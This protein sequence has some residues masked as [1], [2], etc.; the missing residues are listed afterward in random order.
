MIDCRRCGAARN[1][2]RSSC[3]RTCGTR[4]GATGSMICSPRASRTC[5]RYFT[6][7]E[8]RDV[9]LAQ[10]RALLSHRSRESARQDDARLDSRGARLRHAEAFRAARERR[11]SGKTGHSPIKSARS[12][13]CVTR[14]P[15]VA[16]V[17]REAGVNGFTNGGTE[18]T[19]DELRRSGSTASRS[20]ARGRIGSETRT[21]G[22]VCCSCFSIRSVRVSRPAA[23]A[24]R[25]P[26]SVR[27]PLAPLLRL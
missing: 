27:A 15:H 3:R 13:T 14:W 22:I 7:R 18:E 6:H 21:S 26:A 19:E 5:S 25:R 24:G 11:S 4:A 10:S 16:R 20:D 23:Q 12:T 8:D 9:W 2:A 17:N 1:A